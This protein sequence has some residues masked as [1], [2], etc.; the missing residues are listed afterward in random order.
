MEWMVTMVTLMAG[1]G[2]DT[3]TV[4]EEEEEVTRITLCKQ[5][6]FTNSCHNNQRT[7]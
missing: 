1:Q 3:L 4:E 7:T 6:I 5:L 2:T